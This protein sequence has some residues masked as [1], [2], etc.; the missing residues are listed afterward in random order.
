MED[1]HARIYLPDLDIDKNCVIVLK[2]VGPKGNPGMP[3]VGNVDLPEKLIKKGIK[4]MVRISDGR[5]SG[6]DYGTVVLNIS[7]ESAI[8]GALAL[9][10]NGDIIE[11]DVEKRKLHLDVS[12]DELAMCRSIWKA[13]EP[14]ATRGYVKIY[15]DHV[16]RGADLDIL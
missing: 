3:E 7:P 12:E 14:R 4:D 5:M 1:Y 6:T 9:V 16:E 11:F 13:P 8:G 10:N 2:G 15:I